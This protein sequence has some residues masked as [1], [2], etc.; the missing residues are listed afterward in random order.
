MEGFLNAVAPLALIVFVLGITLKLG[1]WLLAVTTPRPI[2]GTTQ[3]FEGGP[4]PL[5]LIPALKAVVVDPVVR[6]HFRANPIWSRG[7]VFY[8][9]AIMTEVTGYSLAGLILLGNILL[10]R[11][12][13]DVGA[14]LAASTN[15]APANLLAIV[16]GN[17]EHLQAQF[18][19]G[20]LAPFFVGITWVA[21]LCAVIGNLHMVYTALRGWG[22]AVLGDI[23]PAA[24]GLR[25]RGRM[26]WDRVAVRLAIFC[27]IWTEVLARLEAVEG[28][29][30]V[31]ALLGLLLVMLFP[32][33]YLFHIVYNF[34]AIFY[35]VQRRMARTIA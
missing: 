5:G 9:I 26:Q 17:G 21:V 13:P 22:G 25:Q 3:R 7:Y 32:F 6:F 12:I 4:A 34:L 2:R 14:H 1:R 30:F 19:F 33:T 28:I 24:R 16:F 35:A 10:G 8:H 23:D 11:P 31:H 20:G 15:Y 29:V 27:I 18:L